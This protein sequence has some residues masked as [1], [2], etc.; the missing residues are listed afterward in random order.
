MYLLFDNFPSN[1]SSE[2]H[3]FF[4]PE[5]ELVVSSISQNCV[6]R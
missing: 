5:P 2:N 1:I 3:L 4:S 6:L